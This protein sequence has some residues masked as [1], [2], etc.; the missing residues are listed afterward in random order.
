MGNFNEVAQ[1][2]TRAVRVFSSGEKGKGKRS[3]ESNGRDADRPESPAPKRVRKEGP[4]TNDD[5]AWGGWIES[6]N[7]RSLEPGGFGRYSE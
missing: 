6:G 7:Q 1:R 5:D 4:P 2:P 3:A